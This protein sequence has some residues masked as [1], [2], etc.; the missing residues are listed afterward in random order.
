[1]PTILP[2]TKSYN[3]SNNKS[4]NEFYDMSPKNIYL[5]DNK[6]AGHNN[7][8]K[9]DKSNQDTQNDKSFDLK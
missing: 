8:A 9:I 3:F 6:S 5:S 7:L 4:H 1:M 2:Q